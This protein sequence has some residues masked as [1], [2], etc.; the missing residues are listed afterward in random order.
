[1]AESLYLGMWCNAVL[2][3]ISCFIAIESQLQQST[4]QYFLGLAIWS[5]M[6][7]LRNALLSAYG[8]L[9][10]ILFM[11]HAR[12]TLQ[13]LIMTAISF[14]DKNHGLQVGDNSGSIH[15]EIYLPPGETEN[16]ARIK[17]PD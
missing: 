16:L 12:G 4:Y 9:A 14:G 1:M 13:Y 11:N 8:S 10:K 15:A 17:T 2:T 5:H 3:S 6:M 7:G